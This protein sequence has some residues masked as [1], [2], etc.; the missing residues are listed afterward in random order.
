MRNDGKTS[1]EVYASDRDRVNDLARL[2]TAEGPGRFGQ[3]E[4]IRF[5]LDAAQQERAGNGGQ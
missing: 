5:L 2:L 3:A 1:I 4:T